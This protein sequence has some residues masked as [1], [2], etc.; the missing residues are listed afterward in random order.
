MPGTQV[1]GKG[2]LYWDKTNKILKIGDGTTALSNLANLLDNTAVLS[3][4]AA[5]NGSNL[6]IS[7]ADDAKTITA[8]IADMQGGGTTLNFVFD[9]E[10]HMEQWI[11]G[12]YTRSDGLVIDDAPVGANF[13]IID[14]NVP[15]YWWTGEEAKPFEGE[16]TNLSS[17][18]NTTQMNAAITAAV[19]A[20]IEALPAAV[21][22]LPPADGFGYEMRDGAW[23]KVI[24]TDEDITPTPN[25]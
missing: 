21:K 16:A 12:D 4:I 20:A 3:A 7:G 9:T 19:Q 11:E 24:L 18:S 14:E 25:P 6:K 10:E 17:Y 22:T 5:L 23:S 15:D 8:A 1:I 13:Y 2:Q